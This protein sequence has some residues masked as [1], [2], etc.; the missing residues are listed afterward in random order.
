MERFAMNRLL[1]W[2]EQKARKP[3]IIRGARQVGKT[4]LARE[5]GQKH[6]E[7]TIYLNFDL[8]AN[9]ESGSLLHSIFEG[10]LDPRRIIS[11][12]EA[13]FEEK[14]D[15]ERSLLILDEIQE[16]PR[17]L[18]SLKYF[19]ELTPEYHIIAAGSHL[20]ITLHKGESFPVG[21]VSMMY[22]YPF[23]FY[24]FLLALGRNRLVA[25]I[26][27]RDWE[28]IRLL[29]EE[30][31]GLLKYYYCIGGMPEVVAS[32]QEGQSLQYIRSLQR[33]ILELFRADFSKHIPTNQLA[34]VWQIWDSIPVHLSKE[35]KKLI[36]GAI[37]QGARAK[38]YE[39]A[40]QWLYDYGLAYRISHIEKPGKPLESYVNPDNFKLF[41]L[42]VGLLGAMAGLDMR[43][44]LDGDKVFTEFKGALTEQYVCQELFLQ[45]EGGHYGRRPYYW[46]GKQAEIDFVALLDDSITPIEVKAAENLRSKSLKSY[47]D[48][49]A[50]ACAMR[51]SL[52][53]YREQENLVNLP[54]YGVR[55]AEAVVHDTITSNTQK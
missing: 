10:S 13:L 19:N 3:L 14:I 29:H 45:F 34:R 15:P 22:L 17:A 31:T 40:L 53:P 35:N 44:V 8:D 9:P 2:S 11:A 33:D 55:E 21:N 46:T 51:V 26:S 12:L 48:R 23:S 36:W 39:E 7:Q 50:P 20:G 6:F 37:R 25:L 32:H 1:E 43:T 28:T 4:W 49:Y 54:L 16:Q 42:D 41:M 5:F 18:N 24:E 47:I 52:S 30:L 27:K 38:E